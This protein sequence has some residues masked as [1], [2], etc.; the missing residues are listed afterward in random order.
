LSA[1]FY[2]IEATAGS[3]KKLPARLGG[4][5]QTP[6]NACVAV[7]SLLLAF[8]FRF[9]DWGDVVE[10]PSANSSIADDR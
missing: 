2:E 4:G 9:L 5:Y 10:N 3:T 7:Y 6:L 1:S 8:R